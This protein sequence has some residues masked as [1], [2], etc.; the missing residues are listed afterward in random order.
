MPD[1]A[2][3]ATV[4]SSIKSATDI[5]KYISD[6]GVTLEKA[7]LKLKFAELVGA[8]ADAK[9]EIA[10]IQNLIL[11]K[12][13]LIKQLNEKLELKENVVFVN[14]VYWIQR[15]NEKDG[16]YCQR[17]YDVDKSLIRLQFHSTTL[18]GSTTRYYSCTAC[19]TNYDA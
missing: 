17:C 3:I 18:Y 19:K 10:N 4:L 9:L 8:L 11:E 16:P 13:D 15:E 14:G 2:T 12:D 5:A 1:L 7:E 6:S